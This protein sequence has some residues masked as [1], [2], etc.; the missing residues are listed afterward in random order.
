MSRSR[1]LGILLLVLALVAA[2]M[3]VWAGTFQQP[4]AVAS[5]SASPSPEPSPSVTT[6]PVVVPPTTKSKQ[7]ELSD[8]RGK[9]V[10]LTVK[11][12]KKVLAT[13]PFAPRRIYTAKGDENKF[14]SQCGA[15]AYWDK[16]NPK[17]PWPRPGVAS[18]K[19]SLITGHV[20]CGKDWYPLQYLQP[21]KKK[22]GK[23]VGGGK[24][25]D[26]LYVKYSSGDVV[27]SVAREDSREIVKTELNT[28]KS[29][30]ENGGKKAREIR[31]TTCDRTGVIRPDGHALKNSVQRFRVIDVIRAKK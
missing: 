7:A 27:E 28:Q 4:M 29:F 12:G 22:N 11:R 23:K 21:I 30:T 6:P 8:P 2:V 18:K 14:G 13:M 9:P 24:K 5:A 16:T 19:K 15:V 3:A 17:P 20:M 26:R 31:L 10:S 25:G 1:L